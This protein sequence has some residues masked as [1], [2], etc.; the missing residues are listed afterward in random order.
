M[1]ATAVLSEEAVS[2]DPGT[3]ATCEVRVRN[4]GK[5]VDEYKLEVLGDPAEW[6]LVEP[7]SL[8]LFPGDEGVA[9]LRFRPP[10]DSRTA[11]GPLPFGLRVASKEDPDGTAVEEGTVEVGRFVDT[12][13]ELI[14]RTSRGRRQ[15]RHEL[16]V[17]NRGNA[18]INARLSAVDPDDLL[19]FVLSPPTVVAEP[20]TSA[21]AKVTV[22][23]RKRFLRGPAR[24]I[25]FQVSAEADGAAPLVADGAMMQ[26]ALVPA[27]LPKAL[28]ALAALALLL[29]IAWLTLLRPSIESAAK[30]GGREAGQQAGREAGRAAGGAAGAQAARQE[31]VDAGILPSTGEP[32]RQPPVTVQGA[33]PGSA[34]DGRLVGRRESY[35]VPE[36]KTLQVTDIILQN[37]NANNGTLQ[38]RRSGT[39]LLV[40]ALE[41]FRDLDYHFVAPLVF[42]AGDRLELDA[43]CTNRGECTPGIYW[44]GFLTDAP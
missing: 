11:T 29:G 6:T 10:R 2:V 23:P 41:N 3:E 21:F 32:P 30:A 18:R 42:K 39:A 25:P 12:F 35:V 19:T 37:P 7:G 4:T 33:V 17:D 13:A 20:G 38:V 44:A 34:I 36:A 43:T 16:A 1:G 28:M 40:V 8:S 24:T 27:W 5:I 22:R 15:A 31:L 26:E 14:P 9:R